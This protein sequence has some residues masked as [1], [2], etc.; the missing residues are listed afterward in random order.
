MN[1]KQTIQPCQLRSLLGLALMGLILLAGFWGCAQ[2]PI[3]KTPVHL[4]PK[5]E[6]PVEQEPRLEA[7][8]KAAPLM[9]ILMAEAEAFAAQENY[10]DA[11][12]IYH[13]LLS[14]AQ[15]Q[16][17][18][19]ILSDIEKILAKT[20]PDLIQEFTQIKNLNLPPALLYYWLGRNHAARENYD[21][22]KK[23]LEFFVHT[24]PDHPHIPQALEIL[25]ALKSQ[26]SHK[27]AIIGSLLPLSG[28]YQVFGE[29]ALQGIQLA[30]QDLYAAHGQDFRVIIKDT[31]SDPQRAMEC[32]DELNQEGV[33]GI[34]GP[35][36]APES[37]GA[38]AQELG[39]PMIAL[40]QKEEFPLEGEYLFSN[41]ITPQ[42]QVQ[43]LAAYAFM[44]LG[45]TTVAIL[46]P[47][48]RYGLRY[49]ELFWEA[50]T[51][52]N[53]TVVGAEAYEGTD[54]DFS[55]PI[56]KLIGK[57]TSVPGVLRPMTWED[58][59]EPERSGDIHA[60]TGD[61]MEKIST[62]STLAWNIKS[63]VGFQA[64]FIPDALSRVTLILPQLAY[65]DAKEMVLL[66]TNLW[67]QDS[68]LTDVKG[69]NQNTVITDGYFGNST[70]PVTAAFDRK[71]RALYETPPG[72]LEAI[73]YD[74]L[75]IL[76]STALDQG[77]DTR[78]SLKNALQE[79]RVFE[80]VTGKT[81]FDKTGKP[82]KEL[83]LITVKNGKFMEIR[84]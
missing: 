57:H 78:E 13:Q 7:P 54:T 64:L 12:L 76:C 75:M 36:L 32:V 8:E 44:K 73:A 37:A 43:S 30:V 52:F 61:T 26:V 17:R 46:Y 18:E 38:R 19:G 45:I 29:K 42:M 72:F 16:D 39:I 84:H 1:S 23:E 27:G 33:L 4:P 63:T 77:V 15:P 65:H 2:K 14:L 79:S 53:G 74:T 82:H 70:N 40:T 6:K 9:E 81:F 31:Q 35:L 10:E 49:K 80:G 5:V 62:D 60:D 11:L 66:G 55:L 41:F 83:F 58:G 56:K 25:A 34:L 47:N 21:Q 3:Q 68:L 67:H 69:Y 59:I 24:F 22:A 28:K 20:D 50:A 48:E 71:F 51:H